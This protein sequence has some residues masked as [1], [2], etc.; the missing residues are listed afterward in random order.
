M[1]NRAAFAGVAIDFDAVVRTASAGQ[2]RI[3][4]VDVEAALP[5]SV[6][7]EMSRLAPRT[8]KVP[9][10]R[11]VP[12]EYRDAGVVA[13]AVKLQLLFGLADSPRLGPR[14]VPVTFELLAPSGRPVQVTSDLRS[15]WS[16]TYPEVRRELRGRVPAAPVAR[17]SVDR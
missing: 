5:M 3:D 12:L 17:G 11:E 10:G 7:R 16:R 9:S 6:R 15:F 1:L 8:L 4:D 14:L 2:T 13:A